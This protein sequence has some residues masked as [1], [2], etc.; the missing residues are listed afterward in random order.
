MTLPA[1]TR[2]LVRRFYA[3][4]WNC[5]DTDA[6]A[7]LF[8]PDCVFRGSLGAERR[9]HDGLAA[10]VREVTGALEG[11]RCEIEALVVEN[12]HAFARMSFH[13]RHVGEFIGFAPTGA[14]VEWAG[15]AHFE[16]RDGRIQS[17]WVLG[18]LAGLRAQLRIS[19]GA[20]PS[21]SCG[22]QGLAA[23]RNGPGG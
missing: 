17:L 13:G 11:Y 23:T 4:V 20:A 3:E 19:A 10:Y 14:H 2:N 5:A 12:A 22:H 8:H 21:A 16:T 7:D 15:A 9:G 6:I 1:A 18:D